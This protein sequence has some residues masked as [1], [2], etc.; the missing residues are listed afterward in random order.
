MRHNATKM[1]A[2][3]Q[4]TSMRADDITRLLQSS[5]LRSQADLLSPFPLLRAVS[6]K[7]FKISTECS[8]L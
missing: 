2:T 6:D 8:Y 4:P 3:R 5:Q 7:H 1:S